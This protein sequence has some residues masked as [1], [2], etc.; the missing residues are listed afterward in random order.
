MAQLNKMW[1]KRGL[2]AAIAILLAIGI[3]LYFFPAAVATNYITAAVA[4]GDI[5]STVLATGTVKP[6]K[7]VDVG[8]QVSGQIKNLKVKLGQEVKKGE[9]V[10]E[11]DARTQKNTV[12]TQVAQLENY[13][14]TLAAKQAS[15]VKA[16]LDFKRQATMFKAGA[17]SKENYD[18]AQASLK[19]AQADIVQAQ[20]QIKQSKLSADSARLTL[21]YTQ[22]VAPID[23]VVVSIAVEEG[24]TVNAA[25]STPTI[26]T[27]AQ[28]DKITVRAEISEGD[29]SKVKA[30]MPA[31]FTILG[32]STNRFE[33]TLSSVDPGPVSMSDNSASTSSTSTA[34]YYYGLLH[35]PNP[36]RKLRV[37]MTTN[38]SIILDQAKQ[39]LTIPSTALGTKNEKGQYR[40]QVL[41]SNKKASERWVTVGL[42]NNINAQITDGLTEGE[43]VVV[44]QTT[45]AS[46]SSTGRK[47][48]MGAGGP[49]GMGM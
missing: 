40:V 38:V 44:S 5:E 32:D 27:I 26:V 9:V 16:T 31:Y 18:A 2:W 46:A 41:D 36:E 7:Q 29:V 12:L 28:L 22:V 17:S 19:I 14:A 8:A 3:K 43:L 45:A 11:I 1:L 33:T 13:T 15:L 24:Q 47:S 34:I 20:A 42:N 48:G 35:M 10:A 23:G 6:F 37:A 25:Q 39:V 4:K 30:G 49:Q 21:S